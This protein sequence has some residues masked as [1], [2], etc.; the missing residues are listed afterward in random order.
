MTPTA[1]TLAEC[2]ERK[3]LACV[4]EKW[5]PQTRQR[6]DAFGFGDLLVVDDQPGA[7][8]IQACSS[9]DMAR[10]EGKIRGEC[11]EA[12]ERWL[13][14]GNRIA[15]WGW[16]LRGARGKRKVWTLRVVEVA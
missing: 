11:W 10:R 8:L 15:V 12:A 5:I 9:G 6:K 1:R 2:K 7:L 4:V 13:A 14:R 3:W 16:A